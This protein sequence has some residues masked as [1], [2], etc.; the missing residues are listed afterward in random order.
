MVNIV[1][2]R[3][4]MIMGFTVKKNVDVELDEKMMGQLARRRSKLEEVPNENGVLET[5]ITRA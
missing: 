4:K 2:I 5:R 1:R 3:T